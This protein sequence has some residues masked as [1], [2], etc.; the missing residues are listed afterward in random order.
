MRDCRAIKKA[1]HAHLE[2]ELPA[3]QA[4]RLAAHVDRCP[5]CRAALEAASRARTLLRAQPGPEVPAGLAAAIKARAW[6]ELTAPVRPAFPWRRVLVPV[7]AA[8]GLVLTVAFAYVVTRTADSP[9]VAEAPPLV[10]DVL[11][12]AT[13]PLPVTD[14]VMAAEVPEAEPEAAA[15]VEPARTRRSPAR[16]SVGSPT[17]P[18]AEESEAADTETPAPTRSVQPPSPPP[19]EMHLAFADEP[20]LPAPVTTGAV[21]APA[22]PAEPAALALTPR[23][24]RVTDTLAAEEPAETAPALEGE[25]ATGVVAGMLVDKFI[26]EHLLE[27]TPALLSV[28]TGT[29]SA[30]LGPTVVQDTENGGRFELCFTNAMR[31]AL[32]QT[33]K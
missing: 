12:S 26:E 13:T 5:Q 9:R 23:I 21:E 30:D 25:M 6:Q 28:V 24:G 22:V 33:H 10:T 20:A 32:A 7:A 2:G 3:E 4:R 16:R 14:E 27:T 1:I 19:A 31:R 8:A 29:P 11:P 18:P 17:E 15:E